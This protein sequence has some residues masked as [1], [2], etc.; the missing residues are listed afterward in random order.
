MSD[1][2]KTPQQLRKTPKP[3]PKVPKEEKNL[4]CR[5]LEMHLSLPLIHK[6][7]TEASS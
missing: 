1:M 3:F 7:F 6:L 4:W 5:T 2:D